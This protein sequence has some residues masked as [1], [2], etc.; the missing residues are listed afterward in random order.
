MPVYEGKPFGAHAQGRA[1]DVE[2]A[3]LARDIAA[4]L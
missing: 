4:F 3:A 1:D 2:L